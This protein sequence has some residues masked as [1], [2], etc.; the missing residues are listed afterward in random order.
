MHMQWKCNDHLSCFISSVLH[1]ILLFSTANSMS[2]LCYSLCLC[3]DILFRGLASVVSHILHKTQTIFVVHALSELI[4][5]HISDVEVE[6]CLPDSLFDLFFYVLSSCLF[7]S[8]LFL[9]TPPFCRVLSWLWRGGC[10]CS[11]PL[12]LW[13]SQWVLS[14]LG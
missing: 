9:S 2:P 7:L 12:L 13:V 8:A 14:W 1:C 11:R 10:P 6:K 5:R 4:W 3:C